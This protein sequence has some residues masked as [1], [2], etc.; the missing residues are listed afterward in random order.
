MFKDF[1]EAMK[2][3]FE[4]IDLALMSYFLGIEVQQTD[5]GIFISQKS[6]VLDILKQ[7]KMESSSTIRTPIAKRL[8]IKKEDIGGLVNP[9]YFKGK[10]E[11]LRYLT[12]TR[13]DIVYGVG[14]ISQ[15]MEKP[16]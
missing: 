4:M 6:Y 1:K 2:Q 15:F 10:I 14:I 9:T 12:S 16:Y 13:L 11:S 3:Q 7:F 8:E 5:D